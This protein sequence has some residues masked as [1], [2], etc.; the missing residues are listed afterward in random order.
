MG[1]IRRSLLA[2]T[3]VGLLTTAA[4]CTSE[5]ITGPQPGDARQSSGLMGSGG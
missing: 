5:S 1:T 4:A 2:L 3:V